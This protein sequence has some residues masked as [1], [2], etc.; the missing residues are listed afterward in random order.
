MKCTQN[1][2]KSALLLIKTILTATALAFMQLLSVFAELSQHIRTC[3]L[4]HDESNAKT[5]VIF[6]KEEGQT[7]FP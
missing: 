1:G 3:R 4:A 5:E 2:T 6:E 7:P